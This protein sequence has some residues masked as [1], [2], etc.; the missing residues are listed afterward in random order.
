MSLITYIQ[1]MYCTSL[2]NTCCTVHTPCKLY[3]F[4][5]RPGFWF[6]SGAGS[7]LERFERPYMN[8]EKIILDP[9]LSFRIRNTDSVSYHPC[10][11]RTRFLFQDP[12]FVLILTFSILVILKC[13][14]YVDNNFGS[15]ILVIGPCCIPNMLNNH[16][17][18]P[19]ADP[20]HILYT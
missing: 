20:N 1:Y 7:E 11:L 14:N 19:Y 16:L 4:C 3:L 9:E 2:G 15:F 10:R 6:G 12:Y 5:T 8:P 18:L 13:V 17:I